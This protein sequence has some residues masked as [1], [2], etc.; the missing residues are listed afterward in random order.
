MQYNKNNIQLE[1]Y[2]YV[3]TFI[4][5]NNTTSVDEKLSFDYIMKNL[6]YDERIAITLYYMEGYT[7]R[8]ISK[9]LNTS[10][11]TIKSRISRAKQKIKELYKEEIKNG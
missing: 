3:N 4:S 8:E 7:N 5:S 2:Q 10:V 6:N 9:I 1:D 11:G